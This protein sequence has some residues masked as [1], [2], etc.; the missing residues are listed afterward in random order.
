MSRATQIISQL[1]E[2]TQELKDLASFPGAR[3]A[4]EHLRITMGFEKGG[5]VGQSNISELADD[6]GFDEADD[7]DED[8]V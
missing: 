4:V 7:E 8:E 1:D 6:G 3:E 5:Y 2:L